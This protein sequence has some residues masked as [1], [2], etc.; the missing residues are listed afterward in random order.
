M[1]VLSLLQSVFL[2]L[3]LPVALVLPF[4]LWVRISDAAHL[5]H[6]YGSWRPALATF[7]GLA[8]GACMLAA[9]W[10]PGSL[11]FAAI[12]ADGGPWDLSIVEFAELVAQRMGDAPHRL[13][14]VLLTD[15]ARLNYGVVAMLV[16]TLFAVDVGLTVASGM[17]GPML[18]AF[19]LDL[20]MA[21]L[22]AGLTVYAAHAG[23]WLLNRLNFWSIAVA[24]LLLQE[25]RYGVLGLF[26]RRRRS[27]PTGSNGQHGFTGRTKGS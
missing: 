9:L 2:L 4:S 25:F 20:L 5:H 6:P 27:P 17:R 15:D 12:F 11:T 16:G 3:A 19:L 13:F 8:L 7:C 14:E 26:R 1:D 18:L 22:A 24:I 23:L 10:Q 21:V